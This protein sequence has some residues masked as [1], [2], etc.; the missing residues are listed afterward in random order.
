[1]ITTRATTVLCIAGIAGIGRLAGAATT[2]YFWAEPV[3]GNWSTADNWSPDDGPPLEEAHA[4]VIDLPG[5]YTVTVNVDPEVEAF[6]MDAADAALVF[7]AFL[8]DVRMSVFTQSLIFGGEVNLGNGATWISV[9]NFRVKGPDALLLLG[10]DATLEIRELLI[11]NQAR[12]LVAE[13]AAIVALVGITIEA[14]SDLVVGANVS[15]DLDFDGTVSGEG[16]LTVQQLAELRIGNMT[17]DTLVVLQGDGLTTIRGIN[18]TETMTNKGTIRGT[19]VIGA[20]QLAIVNG[21]AGLIQSNDPAAPLTIRTNDDGLRNRGELRARN[22]STLRILSTDVDNSDGIIDAGSN[23]FVDLDDG[24]MTITG[25]VLSAA[26][27]GRIRDTTETDWIGL[28]DVTIDGT[29]E[30]RSGG[31]TRLFGTLTNRGLVMLSGSGVQTQLRA[32]SDVTTIDGGGEIVLGDDATNQIR[33][34]DGDEI[35]LN[36]D[37]TI[38]GGGSIGE[39]DLSLINAGAVIA[40]SDD[41]RLRIDPVNDGFFLNLATLQATGSAGLQ[42]RKGPFVTSGNVLIAEGSVLLRN[43]TEQADYRQVL[44]STVVEGELQLEDVV[45]LDGGDL[46]GSGGVTASIVMN[47]A[48]VVRPGSSVGTLTMNGPYEQGPDGTLAIEL[49]GLEPGT[50]HDQLVVTG[51]A[52]LDGALE[53][54]LVDGYQPNDGDAFTILTAAEINGAFETVTDGYTVMYEDTEVIVVAGEVVNGCPADLDGDGTVGFND[55]TLLLGTWGPCPAEGTCDA[56][57]DGDGTVGFND[58]TVLLGSWGPCE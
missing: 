32:D 58:L 55:L 22:E 43:G 46:S 1:M 53:I 10:E 42:I 49:D 7:D 57:I 12:V 17:F 33:G 45:Q 31:E 34:I 26:D 48:G 52:Q 35:L 39:S 6:T 56:D 51:A 3:S 54:E 47:D 28:E 30:V 11:Q 27:T 5:A 29:Y 9:G 25:G 21:N 13:E 23:S 18:G 37:N 19:G 38:R 8:G 14:D 24:P 40:D 4:A 2:E 16:S 20:G 50:G 36:A 41:V 15:L 44:G